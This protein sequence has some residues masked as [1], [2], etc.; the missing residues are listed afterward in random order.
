MFKVGD[1]VIFGRTHGEQTHGTV[2]KV[3]P[4]TVIVAQDEVR[5]TFR[6]RDV[7][8]K[9][10]V[11]F[12]LVRLADGPAVAVATPAAPVVKPRRS[13]DQI[14]LDIFNV[15]ARFS[16]ENLTCDGELRGAAVARRASTLRARLRDL[17]AEMGRKV[18]E[19]ECWDWW[20][21]SGI[22]YV[23]QAPKVG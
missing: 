3:N 22:R 23:H 8:T 19:D 9:W 13:E 6:T 2:V 12:N 10:K 11:P 7:G 4:T 1:K 21:K 15:Y 14:L 20:R 17:Q 16:P 18:S 5:G